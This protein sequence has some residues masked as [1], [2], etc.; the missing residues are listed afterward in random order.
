M[1]IAVIVYCRFRVY[2]VRWVMV[3]LRRSIMAVDR[4]VDCAALTN[5]GLRADCRWWSMIERVHVT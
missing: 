3:R 5:T 4:A 2:D 1:R